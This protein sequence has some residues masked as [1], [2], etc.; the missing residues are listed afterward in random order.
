MSKVARILGIAGILM[1]VGCGGTA[2]TTGADTA[3]SVSASPHT[4]K[5]PG[6]T[7]TDAAG[8]V[9]LAASLKFGES[10]DFEHDSKI[11][12][13]VPL[14]H[15]N[16]TVLSYKSNIASGDD[17]PEALYDYLKGRYSWS[18]LKAKVCYDGGT[19]DEGEEDVTS[20]AVWRWLLELSDGTVVSPFDEDLPGF[21]R[22][23]YPTEDEDL[24]AGSCRTGNVIFAVPHGKNVSRVLYVREGSLPVAWT[25]GST[26]VR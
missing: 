15:G 17:T 26:D 13:T 10:Y 3:P 22:P 16:T 21:P 11:D 24:P 25:P 23:L 5:D 6:A 18:A 7:A 1:T 19:V 20:I 4:A 12:P 9:R 14:N 2:D 8:T